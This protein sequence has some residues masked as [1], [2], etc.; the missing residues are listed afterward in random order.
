MPE[1]SISDQKTE[2]RNGALARR[3][4]MAADERQ[5]GGETIA[6]RPFPLTIAP[7]TIVSG[8]MPL[9]SEINPLPL[10]KVLAGAGAKLALPAIAGRGKPL[11][12]RAYAFGDE[13]ARG[14]W[15]IREPR[16]EQPEVFPDVLL[17]PLACFDRAGQ[18]IGYGAG[19]YDMTIRRLRATKKVVA[20]GM[21]FAV[22]EI[23]TVPA[24]DRDERLD[25]VLTETGTIDFRGH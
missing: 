7:G 2:L 4:A 5:R 16:P 17:V 3:D 1:P 25:L 13:F 8:F 14:Q 22:Q 15:G 20:I 18:R 19:Y 24:T 11:I 23:A 6:A 10:M 21:A 12:M 9:K